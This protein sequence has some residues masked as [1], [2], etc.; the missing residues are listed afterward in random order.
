MFPVLGA[1]EIERLRRFGE[2]R[3]YGAMEAIA[4]AGAAN[5]GLNVILSGSADI[6]QHGLMMRARSWSH[7]GPEASPASSRI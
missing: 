2:P 6:M 3:S 1:S 5:H 4:T 7:S